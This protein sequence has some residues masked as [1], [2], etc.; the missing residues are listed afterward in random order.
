MASVGAHLVTLEATSPLHLLA[1][2]GAGLAAGVINGVAGG[3]TFVTFPTLLALGLPPIVANVTSTVG[4]VPG[5]LGAIAGYRTH[6]A[7]ERAT[8]RTLLPVA[9]G[10]GLAGALALLATSGATFRTVVVALVGLATLLFA[11]QPFLARALTAHR[12]SSSHRATLGLGVLATAVYGGYFGAAMGIVLLVVLGTTSTRP[13]AATSGLRAVLSLA[14][15]LVAALVFCLHGAPDWA[16]VAALAPSSAIGG[17]FGAHL[18]RSIPVA[19]LRGLV[20]AI[21]ASTWL[22]LVLT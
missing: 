7:E 16:L 13:L 19:W 15:N 3:G 11:L 9:V 8:L 4:I 17:L 10:G 14:V 5:Y 21:G 2:A 22:A 20:V 12:P 6:L 18:A 1:G